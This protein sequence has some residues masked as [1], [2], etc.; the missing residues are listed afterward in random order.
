MDAVLSFVIGAIVTYA[1][2]LAAYWLQ[3]RVAQWFYRRLPRYGLYAGTAHFVAQ[4]GMLLPLFF[5]WKCIAAWFANGFYSQ[6]A[7]YLGGSLV[8]IA[9]CFITLKRLVKRFRDDDD[10]DDDD[11]GHR[12]PAQVT[13]H[14]I[15]MDDALSRVHS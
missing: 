13:A 2:N 7:F 8:S 9:M 14:M 12:V 4:I 11:G 10:D 3:G 15:R 6:G 1:L 5:V